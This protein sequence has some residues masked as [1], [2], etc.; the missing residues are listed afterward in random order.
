MSKADY[1]LPI[2]LRESCRLVDERQLRLSRKKEEIEKNKKTLER[3]LTGQCRK[4]AS[5]G[6]SL[7]EREAEKEERKNCVNQGR[8]KNQCA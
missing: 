8:K 1:E 2:I 3:F 6:K 7:C 5:W 4:P